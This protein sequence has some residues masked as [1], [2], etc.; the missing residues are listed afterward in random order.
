VELPWLRE[1]AKGRP[2]PGATA[3]NRYRRQVAE[4]LHQIELAWPPEQAP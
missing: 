4:L 1:L 2:L 3:L